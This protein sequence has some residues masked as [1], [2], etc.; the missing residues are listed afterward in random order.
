MREAGLPECIGARQM[1]E[2]AHL[3]TENPEAYGVIAAAHRQA[4]VDFL[5][6]MPTPEDARR[7][8]NELVAR[9][10]GLYA[11]ILKA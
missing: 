10:P 7:Y 9:D 3:R 11:P 8:L 5:M 6:H 1:E 2:I 4:T